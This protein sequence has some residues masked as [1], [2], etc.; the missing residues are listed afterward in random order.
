MPRC[1]ANVEVGVVGDGEKKQRRQL[2]LVDI[3][4]RHVQSAMLFYPGLI[5]EPRKVLTS[6]FGMS[7]REALRLLVSQEE[8]VC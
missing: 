4:E 6:M 1:G 5:E 2:G 7:K 8:H 3:L